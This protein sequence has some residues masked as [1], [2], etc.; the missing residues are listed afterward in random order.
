MGVGVSVVC[1]LLFGPDNFII[2]AMVGIAAVLMLV[3]VVVP[4]LVNILSWMI[5]L[6]SKNANVKITLKESKITLSISPIFL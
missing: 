4:S 5:S 2:P 6:E 3:G 1:L